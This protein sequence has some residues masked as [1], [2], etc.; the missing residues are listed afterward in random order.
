[1]MAFVVYFSVSIFAHSSMRLDEAQSLFQTNRDVPGILYLVGQDVH[2]PLYHV[3]LHYWQ[4]LFGNDIFTARM[5]SLLFF[6]LTIPMTYILA[7]YAFSRKVGL[8][9]ALLVTI[10]PFLNWYGSEAR[11]YSML[12]F[13]TV[14]HFYMFLKIFRE[15]KAA[16]WIWFTISAVIGVYTHY[17]FAFVLFAEIIFYLLYRHG[18]AA[19]KS[20]RKFLLSGLVVIGVIAPWLYYVRQLGS[21]SNTQPNLGEPTSVD[22][23]NTYSQFV[24]GFQTDTL[25]TVIVSLWPIVVLLAFFGLQR[26]KT[27]SKETLFFAI[28]ATVPVLMAFIVSVTVRP[29]YQSRYLIVALPA[30]L[31]LVSWL[32]SIYP[33]LVAVILRVLLVAV[34]LILFTIQVL[35][36]ATPVKENYQEAASYLNSRASGKDVIVLSAPFTIYPTEY[37]YEGSAKLTT[38]PIWNRFE[39]GSVPGFDEKKLPEE[40]KRNTDSY[41]N[42]W[43]V[44]SFD[45][46]YNDKIKEYFD[47]NF[48]RT[49]QKEFSKDLWVYSYKLRYDK[50]IRVE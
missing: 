46:G 33:R 22:L 16:S 43:L 12:A 21:A 48:E 34:T 41:Q 49:S 45:Q 47:T 11:M 10:S 30:L 28:A 23:F 27:I 7:A 50:G 8:F 31:I 13:I 25:N 9:A 20:F 5:L 42:A 32:I 38:Q 14:F 37:Y 40:V 29:F 39:Q 4:V 24:F 44:L 2:V 35:N 3:V 6:A 17:F 26:N 18:F 15:G 36:P 1:M 19:Q